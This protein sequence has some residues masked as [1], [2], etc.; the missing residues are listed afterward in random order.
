MAVSSQYLI[1]ED[2]AFLKLA[3]KHNADS[4]LAWLDH[5]KDRKENKGKSLVTQSFC[6]I[7]KT[8]KIVPMGPL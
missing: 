2:V 5:G 1:R 6:D 4:L 7:Q 3:A 8:E